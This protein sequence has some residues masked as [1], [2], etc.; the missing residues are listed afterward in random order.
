MVSLKKKKKKEDSNTDPVE[1]SGVF[2]EIAAKTHSTVFLPLQLQSSPQPHY[3]RIRF[4][5]AM[6]MSKRGTPVST[7]VRK[8]N[9]K[10]LSSTWR[11]NYLY[12]GK[13]GSAKHKRISLQV[14]K[15]ALGKETLP[16]RGLCQPHPDVS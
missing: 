2:N 1:M 7:A 9:R 13:P 6:K 5:T 8:A 16:T 12:S 3:G 10:P 4:Q 11:R 14:Y 15:E